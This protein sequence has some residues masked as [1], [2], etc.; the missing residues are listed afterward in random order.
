[1]IQTQK[2]PLA[3]PEF[4]VF[5]DPQW[6]AHPGPAGIHE[7]RWT[8][9]H[10]AA[11]IVAAVA[12]GLRPVFAELKADGEFPTGLAVHSTPVKRLPVAQHIVQILAGTAAECR[13]GNPSPWLYGGRDMDTVSKLIAS[14]TGGSDANAIAELSFE[15]AWIFFR[16][17]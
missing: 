9:L 8:A 7:W 12:A 15:A 5:N 10:E 3:I 17:S 4:P 16:L 6:S 1:M 2:L 13:S 11:H 14:A